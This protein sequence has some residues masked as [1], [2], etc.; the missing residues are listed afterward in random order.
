[1]VGLVSFVFSKFNKVP[2]SQQKCLH[3]VKNA[4]VAK[5]KHLLHQIILSG[6]VT[7]LLLLLFIYLLSGY[8]DRSMHGL[9][10]YLG[11]TALNHGEVER[12]SFSREEWAELLFVMGVQCQYSCACIATLLAVMKHIIIIIIIIIIVALL[13]LMCWQYEWSIV[14]HQYS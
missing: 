10:F 6:I 2:S 9:G 5:T 14:I 8:D 13:F 3:I 1:M 7:I 12:E 4:D 11:L